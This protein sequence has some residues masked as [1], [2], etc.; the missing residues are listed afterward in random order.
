MQKYLVV[1]KKA[2]AAMSIL[3]SRHTTKLV[4]RKYL[5]KLSRSPFMWSEAGNKMP[6]ATSSVAVLHRS[7][8]TPAVYKMM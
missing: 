4:G 6:K 2:Q 8:I 5:I 7:A 1:L 3:Y